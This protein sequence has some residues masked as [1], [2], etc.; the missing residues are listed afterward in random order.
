MPRWKLDAL[1]QE[2]RSWIGPRRAKPNRIRVLLEAPAQMVLDN[3]EFQMSIGNSDYFTMRT[4][5]GLSKKSHGSADGGPIAQV[6]SSWWT[7]A[8]TRFGTSTVPYHLS[9]LGV[10]FVTDP[11][12]GF[13]Y[14]VLTLP[15]AQR[16]PLVPG[17]NASFAEQ[18]WAPSPSGNREPWWKPYVSGLSIEAPKDRTGDPN[19]WATVTR[20]LTEE[21]GVTEADLV[22]PPRLVCACLEQDMHFLGFVFVLQASLTLDQLQRRRLSSADREI[23]AVA[24]YPI[25]GTAAD[26]SR[27]DAR[28]QLARILSMDRFDGGPYLLPRS[29]P[30]LSQGWHLSSRLRIYAAARHLEGNAFQDYVSTVAIGDV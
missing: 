23:G 18:M 9:A 28:A 29:G 27:L 21:L 5:D 10:L 17:W 19:I 25:D 4:I 30:S 6:F 8:G 14:L 12:N 2:L 13:R 24:A 20:G 7:G 22:A 3:N 11:S 26:G 15:N 16:S 1:G